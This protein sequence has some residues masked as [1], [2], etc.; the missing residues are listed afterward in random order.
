MTAALPSPSLQRL[1][2]IGIPLGA[3][4]L[5]LF[6]VAVRFPYD[7]IRDVVTA[8][9]S[10][11][12]GAQVKVASLGPSFSLLGPGISVT[13]L[14]VLLPGGQR[15]QLD[16]A[17]VRP[18]WS[19]SWLRGRPALHVDLA[20]PQGRAVGT[21]RLGD[22]PGFDGDLHEVDLARLPLESFIQGLS[23]DGIAEAEIDVVRTAAGPRGRVSIEATSGSVALPGVP[24]ALPFE[25]LKASTKLTD[26]HLAEGLT[27]DLAGPMLTARVS[28]NVGQSPAPIAAPL[29]LQLTLRVVDPSIQPMLAGTGLRFAPDG[30]AEMRLTGT[31]GRPLLR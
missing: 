31:A 26:Q 12:L 17:D 11:A 10:Q 8:Q 20:G 9:A 30:S 5:T 28:G 21:L 25:T 29:D 13:G 15:V 16:L 4:L 14:D 1:Q 3:V 19:T 7:R 24:V 27:L 6:F 2:R 23:L 18:A 22:E